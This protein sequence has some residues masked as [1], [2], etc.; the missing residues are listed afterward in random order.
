MNNEKKEY[1]KRRQKFFD[2]YD[3]SKT[4]KSDKDFYIDKINDNNI[5]EELRIG[6]NGYCDVL[7][8]NEIWGKELKKRK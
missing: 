6:A 8:I 2:D 3:K 7:N 1:N 5:S 4:K